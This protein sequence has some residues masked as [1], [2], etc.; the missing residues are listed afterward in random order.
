[1]QALD[2]ATGDLLWEYRREFP[3]AQRRGRPNRNIAIYEGKIFL[4]TA[5]ANIV[6]LDTRSG[7]VVWETGRRRRRRGV[8][9]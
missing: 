2:A 4:N 8:L 1:M 6:A 7:D 3:T 5:D 9:L